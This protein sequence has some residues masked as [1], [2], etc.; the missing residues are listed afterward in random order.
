MTGVASQR[1]GGGGE[2]TR[3]Q[4]RAERRGRS[5]ALRWP[6]PLR[7]LSLSLPPLPFSVV[8]TAAAGLQPAAAA[9]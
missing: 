1:R 8:A 9:E 3:R 4:T 7:V 2:T 6:P 5:A